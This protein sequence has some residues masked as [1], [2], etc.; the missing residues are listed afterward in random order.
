MNWLNEI[1][2]KNKN[3]LLKS[4]KIKFSKRNTTMIY[5]YS[6]TNVCYNLYI[7]KIYLYKNV[8]NILI[9]Q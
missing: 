7:L 4:A 2:N 6:F 3:D 1:I 5:T 9:L 8:Y